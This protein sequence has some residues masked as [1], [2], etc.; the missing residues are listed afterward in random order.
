MKKAKIYYLNSNFLWDTG[1][2]DLKLEQNI[3]NKLRT[4]MCSIVVINIYNQVNNPSIL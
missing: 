4:Y 1:R 2:I 3:W